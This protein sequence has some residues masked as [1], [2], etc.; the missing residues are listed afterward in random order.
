MAAS[1]A[2]TLTPAGLYCPLGDFHIDPL[3]AVARAVITHGHS[4]HA[5]RGHG[6]VLATRETLDIMALRYG[7]G[8]TRARQVAAYGERLRLGE[9]T[10]SL[11][12]AGHVLGSAQVLIE[13]GGYR[14]IVSGDYKRAS[15]TTCAPFEPLRCEAFITEATFGLP[16]FR[17]PE[18]HSEIERLIAS[19]S[20]FPERV[21]LLGAYSLG[22]A[23]R[24]MAQLRAAGYGT[25]VWIHPALEKVT[26][27]YQAC[28]IGLGDIRVLSPA[29]TAA[30][31]GQ[32]VISPPG[33]SRA[34]WAPELP[35]PLLVAASGWMRT[36]A[37]A[38]QSGAQLPL[39]ISDHADWDELCASVI[40]T[41]CEEVWITHGAEHAL[42]HWATG[43]GLRARPLNLIGYGD[44]DE[45]VAE[46]TA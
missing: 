40:D 16:V 6:S 41:G 34:G 44:E 28:G 29:Q 7:A 18:A 11:H 23:Q 15:D 22:K 39:V 12:P 2:L 14:V 32:I 36:R 43:R 20:L 37:R 21:H 19:C 42:V 38:R 45:T 24:V 13:T 31:G 5:R 35:D 1:D 46:A 3:R 25:P 26:Q 8:F 10:V 4:D 17:H 27:Y 30:L 9:T 33:A